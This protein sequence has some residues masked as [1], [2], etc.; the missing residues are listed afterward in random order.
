MN[1]VIKQDFHISNLLLIKKGGDPIWKGFWTFYLVVALTI[2]VIITPLINSTK[3]INPIVSSKVPILIYILLFVYGLC[4]LEF[5]MKGKIRW[6][7]KVS[8]IDVALI[9][10]A[11]YIIL[12]RY[13]I[14]N[15]YNFSLKFLEFLCLMFFYLLNRGL[16]V[17]S[18]IIIVMGFVISGFIQAFYGLLQLFSLK[19]TLNPA[20]KI[21]GSFF[22]P[23]PYAGYLAPILVLL[24]AIYLYRDKLML[25][26]HFKRG[27]LINILTISSIIMIVL[28][29][30]SV[31]SRAGLISAFCGIIFL[32]AYKFQWKEKFKGLHIRKKIF[33]LSLAFFF[34]IIGATGVYYLKKDSSDGRILIWKVTSQLIKKNPVFG[35]GYDRFKTFYMDEQAEYFKNNEGDTNEVSIADNTYYAFNEGLQLLSENGII[36]LLIGAFVILIC[37][38]IKV[39]PKYK[40]LQVISISVI[41]SLLVFSF[42][43]YP[44]HI[45]SI[46]MIGI[47][48]VAN[49]ANLDRN[50][51]SILNRNKY[52]S[53]RTQ[54]LNF[55]V[56]LSILILLC[57]SIWRVVLPVSGIKN[58]LKN[59][60]SGIRLYNNEMYEQSTKELGKSMPIFNRDGDFLMLFGKSLL[61]NKEYKE[62]LKIFNHSKKHL[63][64]T[65]I[66]IGLGDSYKAIGEYENAERSYLNAA[67]MVP[68]RFYPDYLLFTLYRDSGDF[69]KAYSVADKFFNK[70]IKV[71]SK[72]IEE[73]KFEIKKFINKNKTSSS[74]FND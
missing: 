61:L 1:V 25:I 47:V 43:S 17:Q 66:E 16:K 42:F 20:F 34:L 51:K 38:V 54:S 6:T 5:V 48:F 46:K 21:T 49:L 3:W 24:I 11:L 15:S 58:G 2:I 56:R 36:G 28:V 53:L 18:L 12:N 55:P 65:V 57:F 9:T 40:E 31:H 72:A 22:N 32:L 26:A 70:K 41:I 13:W 30:P 23:G 45:L 39:D 60:A 33:G 37:F 64:N 62:S 29:L 35:I 67:A 52:K 63:N 10:F 50:K 44:S 14:Q 59:W 73:M 4:V 19:P 7:I 69:E 68:N 8:K 71:K 27:I 74:S